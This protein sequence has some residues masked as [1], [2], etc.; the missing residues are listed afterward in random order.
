MATLC[1]SS[2]H[3]AEGA[4]KR[5]TTP[6]SSASTTSTGTN[7]GR[8]RAGRGRAA[9]PAGR[10]TPAGAGMVGEVI[11]RSV[12]GP[13]AVPALAGPAPPGSVSVPGLLVPGLGGTGPEAGLVPVVGPRPGCRGSGPAT[14]LVVVLLDVDL[15]HVVRGALDDVLHGQHRGE[16]RVVLVVV[17]E[18]PVAPDRVQVGG[19]GVHPGADGL[20][21]LLVAGLVERVGLGHPDDE[22]LLDVGGLD[23]PEILE[24]GRAL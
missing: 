1:A 14:R 18:H 22:S 12:A 3:S 13:A 4:A 24:L 21:V 17:P 23:Q 7:R 15:P 10:R 19:V 8:G 2:S 9:E 11:G 5:A 6:A 16:H 20:Q